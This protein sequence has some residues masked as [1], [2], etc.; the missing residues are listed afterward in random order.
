MKFEG[1]NIF[2]N[3][4]LDKNKV[5]IAARNIVYIW[6]WR[7]KIQKKVKKVVL[8]NECWK[9]VNISAKL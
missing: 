9:I 5:G 6:N 2:V 7:S 4:R 8:N 3:N 1:S